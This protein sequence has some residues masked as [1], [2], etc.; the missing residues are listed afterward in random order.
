MGVKLKI[1]LIFILN[2]NIIHKS[3]PRFLLTKKKG[4]IYIYIEMEIDIIEHRR[5]FN[6]MEQLKQ[7]IVLQYTFSIVKIYTLEIIT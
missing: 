5:I 2:P 7:T 1:A 3:K 6:Y 4:Y